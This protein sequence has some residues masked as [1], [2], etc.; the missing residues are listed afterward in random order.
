MSVAFLGFSMHMIHLVLTSVSSGDATVFPFSVTKDGLAS[1]ADVGV[2]R[3]LV[4]QGFSSG[5]RLKLK[6]AARIKNRN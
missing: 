1:A 5:L 6:P 3:S 2:K 4:V